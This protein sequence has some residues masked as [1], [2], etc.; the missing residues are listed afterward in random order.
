MGF[1]TDLQ[2]IYNGPALEGVGSSRR[3]SLKPVLILGN[4]FGMVFTFFLKDNV[5][6]VI[7]IENNGIIVT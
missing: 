5:H 4:G 3:I 6:I 1:T 2:R 7:A